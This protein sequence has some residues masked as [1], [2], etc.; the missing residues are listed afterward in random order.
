MPWQCY[1]NSSS[2]WTSD[3]GSNPYLKSL[4]LLTSNKAFTDEI[5]DICPAFL[6]ENYFQWKLLLY[7]I[8]V[9]F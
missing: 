7:P 2:L 3:R 5:T 4:T 9:Y 6:M 8:S 1:N